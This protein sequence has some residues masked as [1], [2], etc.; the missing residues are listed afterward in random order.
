MKWRLNQVQMNRFQLLNL[1]KNKIVKYRLAL[2]LIFLLEIL[3]AIYFLVNPKFIEFY[4]DRIL[5]GGRQECLLTLCM[6]T[7]GAYLCYCVIDYLSKRLRISFI[8]K[9]ILEIKLDCMSVLLYKEGNVLKDSQEG[10]V[11]HIFSED[12]TILEKYFQS[13]V[14]DFFVSF[15]L[16]SST[17]IALSFIEWKLLIVCSLLIPIPYIAMKFIGKINYDRVKKRREIYGEYEGFLIQSLRNWKNIK[18]QNLQKNQLRK[19]FDYRHKIANYDIR[20][21]YLEYIGNMVSFLSE[22]LLTRV[23]LYLLG[24]LL[25][26]NGSITVGNL[27]VFISY[28]EYF[29]FQVKKLNQLQYEFTS[30]L[31]A[32]MKVHELAY[33]KDGNMESWKSMSGEIELN[34]ASFSYGEGSLIL[35]KIN[36]HIKEGEK[37]AIVGANG[38]GKTSLLKLLIKMKLENVGFVLQNFHVFDMSFYDNIRMFAPEASDIEI[39]KAYE[40]VGLAVYI[41][42]LPDKYN[43]LIGKDGASL[44]GGQRQR[45]ALARLLPEKKNVLI[46]DEVSSAMDVE[47]ERNIFSTLFEECKKSTIIYISHRV[48]P[49]L[50]ADRIIVLDKGMI[51]G[52]GKYDELIRDNIYFQNIFLHDYI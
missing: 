26:L 28:F 50:L 13:H 10:D 34:N 2:S 37:V 27:L 31:P 1:F 52:E 23:M 39:E 49:L 4:V 36:L 11:E 21:G 42:S 43:S 35:E 16:C 3:G 19:F 40:K 33:S 51:V 25:I 24:G 47:S 18:L 5:L 48:E 38:S 29:Y 12:F 14:I 6:I 9:L 22:I 7:V 20:S 41:E 8:H 32:L 17:L 15:L 46:L 30:D 44:S 45:V